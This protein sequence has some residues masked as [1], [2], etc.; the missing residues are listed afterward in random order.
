MLRECQGSTLQLQ[1][2][3]QFGDSV[4]LLYLYET[5]ISMTNCHHPHASSIEVEATWQPLGGFVLHESIASATQH[6]GH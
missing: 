1:K 5:K 3:L 4:F 6:V 2:V